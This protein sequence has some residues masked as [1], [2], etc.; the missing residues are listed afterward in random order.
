MYKTPIKGWAKKVNWGN[1][2]SAISWLSG[3]ETSTIWSLDTIIYGFYGVGV[4]I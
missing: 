4:Q 1:F 3:I 2:P